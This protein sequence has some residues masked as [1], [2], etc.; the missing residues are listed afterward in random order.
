MSYIKAEHLKHNEM[1]KKEIAKQI[2]TILSVIDDQIRTAHE[3]ND[4]RELFIG[5]PTTF[6]ITGMKNKTCQIYIYSGILQS[7]LRR[8]F[9]PEIDMSDTQKT[10]LYVTWYTQEEKREMENLMTL[11]TKYSK[12][13]NVNTPPIDIKNQST[14]N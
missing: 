8:G 13:I 1:Q 11:L 10:I 9:F 2:H 7:L 4:K 5:L 12:K 14:S 3:M 6:T